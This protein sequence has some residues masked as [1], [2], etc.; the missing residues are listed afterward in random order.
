MLSAVFCAGGLRLSQIFSGAAPEIY[1]PPIRSSAGQPERASV[2]PP[3]PAPARF[4]LNAPEINSPPIRS[5]TGQL[6]PDPVTL[7]LHQV[8][9][10][11]QEK[12]FDAAL[13]KVNAV[14]LAAPQNADV[15]GMRGNIYA[16]KELWDL[17][18][19]DYQT[20]LQ[21]DGNDIK[22]KFNLAEVD[23]MRKK[24]DD[25][26]PGFLAQEKD[27]DIGDLATYKVFLC[28]LFGGHDDVAAKELDAF[29][30]VGSNASYYFANAAWSL[31]HHKTENARGW[32]MSATKIY[33][34]N[35]FKLYAASLIALGYI[36]LPPPPQQ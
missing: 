33:A 24:Y 28:D 19:K 15:Y 17:A 7:Q 29:N 12:Q 22:M 6:Q 35:K 1:S 13:D 26:R 25:A 18:W 31:Y 2:T 9:Q 30:Q 8:F 34:P 16:Q 14:L 27:P 10:L 11:V 23:F 32:L 36:P 5:S 3:P 4:S 21:F 20:A